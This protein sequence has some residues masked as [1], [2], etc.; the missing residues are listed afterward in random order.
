VV[1]GCCPIKN[2]FIK[3]PSNNLTA[4]TKMQT[5]GLTRNECW[6]AVQRFHQKEWD[7]IQGKIEKRKDS[8]QTFLEI[9]CSD[10]DVFEAIA[11]QHGYETFRPLRIWCSPE[12]HQNANIHISWKGYDT[13]YESDVGEEAEDGDKKKHAKEVTEKEIAWQ[14]IRKYH[15]S[16]I[17]DM[18]ETIEANAKRGIAQTIF[19]G[20]ELDRAE[21]LTR[22]LLE[23]GFV[24]HMRRL[25]IL[26]DLLTQA[27]AKFN[28]EVHLQWCYWR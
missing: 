26:T 10:V 3:S 16:T 11:Q 7:Y 17:C 9:Q 12:N 21:I 18:L 2:P 15:E 13:D 24:C 6:K 22:I 8:G 1:I 20:Y 27:P 4:P 23:K 14:H 19:Y 28:I 25:F 5:T